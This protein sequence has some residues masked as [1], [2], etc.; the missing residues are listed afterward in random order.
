MRLKHTTL[1]VSLLLSLSVSV[2]AQVSPEVE[3]PD[4]VITGRQ[5]FD[6]P[7]AEKNAGKLVS[8]ISGE[9][10]MQTHPPDE[11]AVKEYSE[12]VKI[13]AAVSDTPD[14]KAW[15]LGFY[16][17]NVYL[18]SADLSFTLPFG[19]SLLYARGSGF[20][21]KAFIDYGDRYTAEGQVAYRYYIPHNQGALGGASAFGSAS[22]AFDS[23]S[24][25]GSAIPFASREMVTGDLRVGFE[26]NYRDD[27]KYGISLKGD[28]ANIN[29]ESYADNLFLSS[30]YADFKYRNF[31]INADAE[32]G[33]NTIGTA[34]IRDASEYYLN[35]GATIGF[36][37]SELLSFTV[38]ASYGR[39]GDRDYFNPIA[40]ALFKVFSGFTVMGEYRPAA[41]FVRNIDLLNMNPYFVPATDDHFY[42][43]E[44]HRI[45]AAFKFEY[46]KWYKIS[47]GITYYQADAYPYFY[48]P[49][50]KGNF[51]AIRDEVDH[52]SVFGEWWMY[53]GPAG[54][55]NA[56]LAYTRVTLPNG[57]LVPYH[58]EIEGR[59]N[60]SYTFPKFTL[61][62]GGKFNANSY[63]D[64][65]NAVK[66]DPVIDLSVGGIYSVTSAFEVTLDVENILNRENQRWLNYKNPGLSILAGLR[67]RW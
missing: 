30:G 32:F 17:G 10:L 15:N 45:T 65:A 50:V 46:Y 4:F 5:Q 49:V 23:Y 44:N 24:F 33:Y 60:Y 27:F 38:G 67:Y 25:Y 53:P 1:V 47:G 14:Y 22:I 11:L 42:Y 37:F 43:R 6:F 12:P 58:P 8:T 51:E 35:G 61:R 26:N 7:A 55:V 59:L 21:R 48:E 19:S 52:F 2:S 41:R 62:V 34:L 57:N 28:L 16:A 56:S 66:L 3:L 18:P 64:A 9:F 20:N 63:A 29:A 40:G 31:I 54:A 36:D 13:V 39:A